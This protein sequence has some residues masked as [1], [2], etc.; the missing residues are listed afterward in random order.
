MQLRPAGSQPAMLRPT[1]LLLM[2]SLLP[3]TAS[4]QPAF[5]PAT[6]GDA[7]SGAPAAR[8]ASFSGEPSLVA[9]SFRRRDQDDLD[10]WRDA[11]LTLRADLPGLL[12]FDVLVLPTSVGWIGGLIERGIRKHLT[13]AEQTRT[14]VLYTDPDALLPRLGLAD[15]DE[16]LVL[17]LDSTGAVAWS[18]RGSREPAHRAE[19][20]TAARPLAPP[21]PGRSRVSQGARRAHAA[22][23]ADRFASPTALIAACRVPGPPHSGG[24][25]SLC[26]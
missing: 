16:I 19:I 3:T 8:P 1:L 13:E 14:V 25:C 6:A 5:F 23:P 22:R 10:T 11:A 18:T 7:L 17:L 24:P 12:H 26:S 21:P 4:A 20:L 2:L 15:D 9:V